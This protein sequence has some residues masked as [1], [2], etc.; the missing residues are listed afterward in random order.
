MK[1]SIRSLVLELGADV[2]GFAQVDRFL[3]A[4][5]GFH[6]VDLFKPCRTAIV[7]GLAIP[8][9]LLHVDSKLIYGYYNEFICQKVDEIALEAAR[10]IERHHGCRAVPLPCDSP[11]EYWDAE[12]M[13]GRGLLSM[14]HAAVLAG[15]GTLGKS[16]LL[17][18]AQ[19]GNRLTVGAILTDLELDSDPLA[20][21]VCIKGC[22][23]CVQHCP[24]HALDGKRVNQKKCRTYTY[25]KTARGFSTTNCNVCRTVC[26]A[27]AGHARP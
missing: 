1:E 9:G 20:E 27:A 16:T 15:L 11:Y 19:Y 10:L 21:P 2:C 26:P 5:T 14:K 3:E 18:N 24:T 22:N 25:G 8:D 13:E 7:F 4:P 6:P 23:K 17:L 12:K